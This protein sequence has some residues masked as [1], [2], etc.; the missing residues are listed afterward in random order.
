MALSPL[1]RR[2]SPNMK[3]QGVRVLDF[4]QFMAGPLISSVMAD[5][6]AEVLKIE[7]RSGDPTRHAGRAAE[8]VASDF[9]AAINRGKQSIALDLKTPEAARIVRALVENAD[10]LIESFSP[11]VTQRLGI[12]YATVGEWNPKLVYCSVTAF[13]QNGPLRDLPS[14][15]QLVQAMAGSF[16]LDEQGTPLA[17]TVPIAGAVSAYAALSGVLMALLSVRTGGDGDHLDLSM[18]DATLT[19]RPTSVGAAL[20]A[21]PAPDAFLHRTGVALLET[22]ETADGRWISLGAHE[23]R[24]ARALLG[25]LGRE[26]LVP[27]AVGKPGPA[28]DPVRALLAQTF[29]ENTLEHWLQW[30][31]D[32]G[33]SLGPVLNFAQALAHPHATS[34]R[35]ALS[36]PQGRPHIGTPLKFANAPGE[37]RLTVAAVGEHTVSVLEQA[38]FDKAAIDALLHKGVVFSE[39][40]KEVLPA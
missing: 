21:A 2:I 11:G 13:G 7:S 8:P 40:C 31:Q 16:S 23:P 10:V 28:Q 3:L 15:D 6:G 26:D 18:F 38:G 22:F 36:D 34:R 20:R 17:P 32:S 39:P 4:S 25:R 30:S 24:F 19:S 33:L 12:D 5:H 9:F 37:P 29:K 27:L 1:P 35:M 14:H